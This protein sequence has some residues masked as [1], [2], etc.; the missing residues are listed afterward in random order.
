MTKTHSTDK[1][2]RVTV[3]F[4]LWLYDSRSRSIGNDSR[5]LHRYPDTYQ[6]MKSL[7]EFV[8]SQEGVPHDDWDGY[9][10]VIVGTAT[11]PADSR[12]MAAVFNDY[13]AEYGWFLTLVD[14][15]AL[16]PDDVIVRDP[17][18]ITLGTIVDI[19]QEREREGR[20]DSDTIDHIVRV[21]NQAGYDTRPYTSNDVRGFIKPL[22]E[23]A[24]APEEVRRAAAEALL[25]NTF[26]VEDRSGNRPENRSGNTENYNKSHPLLSWK[27][28]L[29]LDDHDESS[30][31]YCKAED[32]EAAIDL[33]VRRFPG[34][35]IGNVEQG[36]SPL[37]V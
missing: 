1:H 9:L 16:L 7:V 27:V 37:S 26:T 12:E 24:I 15:D 22:D 25:D 19:L 20:D 32:R 10:G 14:N 18:E 3:P 4:M 34:C 21:L 17:P 28:T 5:F 2:T 31:F 23:A 33:A 8:L 6:G 36:P 29:V 35:I 13:W 30:T 11:R